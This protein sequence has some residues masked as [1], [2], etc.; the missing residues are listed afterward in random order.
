MRNNGETNPVTYLVLALVAGAVFYGY[1]VG[2]LYYDNLAA[3]D[4]AGEGF[5]VFILKGEAQAVEGMLLKANVMSPDTSHYEVDK[6][7]VESVKPGYGLTEDNITIV[8]DENTR[9]LTVRIEYDR[10][11][12]FKPLK[13]RKSYHLVAEKTGTVA[14]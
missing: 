3:R 11:V 1:H 10:I 8:F 9:K 6:E 7:G 2:P 5:S 4:I 14:K 13:K 12:E